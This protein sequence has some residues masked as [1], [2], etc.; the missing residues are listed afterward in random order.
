MLP[1]ERCGSAALILDKSNN[2]WSCNELLFNPLPND[3]ILDMT[4]LK[5]FADDKLNVAKMTIFLFV[6][7]GKKQCG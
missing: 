4:K 5:A 6:V 3:K 1:T 7:K 2:M